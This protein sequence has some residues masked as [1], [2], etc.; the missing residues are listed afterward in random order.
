MI[1][2]NPGILATIKQ[3][4]DDMMIPTLKQ[5]AHSYESIYLEVSTSSSKAHDYRDAISG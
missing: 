5:E 3:N 4:L 1:V 2:D